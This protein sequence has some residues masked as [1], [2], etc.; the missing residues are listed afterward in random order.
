[1]WLINVFILNSWFREYVTSILHPIPLHHSPHHYG[2]QT[3]A[4]KLHL[5]TNNETY[6][7]L[8]L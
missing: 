5:A 2:V 7:K 4:P 3:P 1:M 8:A 6:R